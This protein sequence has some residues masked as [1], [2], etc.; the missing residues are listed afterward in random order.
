[1]HSAVTLLML[2][3]ASPAPA[4]EVRVANPP[5]VTCVKQLTHMNKCQLLDLY[6][7]AEAGPMP[8]GYTPGRVIPNPGKASNDPISRMIQLSIWQGKHFDGNGIMTNKQFGVRAAKGHVFSG[9]S[10]IDGKPVHVIDYHD[11]W[12]MWRPYMDELR[13]VAPG[14]YLGITWRFDGCCPKFFTYF[15]LDSRK[16]CC[17]SLG[18][19]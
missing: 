7:N 12:R 19:K 15:A 4:D 6:R 14:I 2:T 9:T 1:M 5:T 8:A 17:E 11:S 13:E 3:F 10:L 16:G 18:A